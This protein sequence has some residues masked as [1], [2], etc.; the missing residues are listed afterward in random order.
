[1]SMGGGNGMTMWKVLLGGLASTAL[2][3]GLSAGISVEESKRSVYESKLSDLREELSTAR[4]ITQEV[5]V[6]PPNGKGFIN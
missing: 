6:L 2:I 3:A 5:N 1:M 4:R